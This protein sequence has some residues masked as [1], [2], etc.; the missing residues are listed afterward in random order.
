MIDREIKELDL[1]PK[2]TKEL[3]NYQ[4]L[5]LNLYDLELFSFNK[6]DLWGRDLLQVPKRHIFQQIKMS[7]SMKDYIF[8]P[9]KRNYEDFSYFTNIAVYIEKVVLRV[10]LSDTQMMMKVS[11]ALSGGDE[12]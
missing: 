9:D 11:S 6:S 7:L 1:D 5:N 8:F 4:I 12:Q 10:C 2:K 3:N